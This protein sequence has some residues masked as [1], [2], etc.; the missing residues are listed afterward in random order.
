M[1]SGRPSIQLTLCVDKIKFNECTPKILKYSESYNQTKKK[2]TNIQ[3]SKYFFCLF[4]FV[5]F[6]A[7][8]SNSKFTFPTLQAFA[9]FNRTNEY[10]FG[11]NL[12]FLENMSEHSSI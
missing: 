12:I 8:D 9:Y 1:W 6:C 2:H 4:A 7:I 11:A 3:S 10:P 5:C